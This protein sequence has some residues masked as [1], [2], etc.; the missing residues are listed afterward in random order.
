MGQNASRHLCSGGVTYLVGVPTPAKARGVCG[1]E[2][3][4]FGPLA[5]KEANVKS[6][7]LT[8]ERGGMPRLS[9]GHMHA[10]LEIDKS[11]ELES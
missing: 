11:S 6:D 8:F 5:N 7:F 10:A 4:R 9:I 3:Q 1:G 2:K